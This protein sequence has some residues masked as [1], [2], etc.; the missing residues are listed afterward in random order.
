MSV[1]CDAPRCWHWAGGTATQ[2]IHAG[3]D[4]S[5]SPFQAVAP[6][7]D[8]HLQAERVCAVGRSAVRSTGHW[9]TRTVSLQS[10]LCYPWHR[11]SFRRA[12]A[13]EQ[14]VP[15]ASAEGHKAGG[16]CGLASRFAANA[17]PRGRPRAQLLLSWRPCVGL[18]RDTHP[19]TTGRA[20]KSDP[21]AWHQWS[22][23]YDVSLT[24]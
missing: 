18:L 9:P 3:K 23:G 6:R 1:L 4:L 8:P 10:V 19:Q 17:G 22:S 12:A 7:S 5:H 20:S 13:A 21:G 24:R 15:R 11:T 16:L 14:H 2:H